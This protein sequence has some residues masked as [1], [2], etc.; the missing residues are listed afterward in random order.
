LLRIVTLET[1][2]RRTQYHSPLASVLGAPFL[3]SMSR[4]PFVCYVAAYHSKKFTCSCLFLHWDGTQVP[5]TRL[6]ELVSYSRIIKDYTMDTS[7]IIRCRTSIA[8]LPTFVVK[9]EATVPSHQELKKLV[10]ERGTL[11]SR[12]SYQLTRVSYS[13]TNAVPA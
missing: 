2:H 13:C 5:V 11:P 9:A 4:C 10:S 8:Q 7:W 3:V 1:I 6:W 12:P